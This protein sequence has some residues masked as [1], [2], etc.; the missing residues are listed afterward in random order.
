ML[1]GLPSGI[2]LEASQSL[3]HPF[4][5]P[6]LEELFVFL[7]FGLLGAW[8]I[9]LHILLDKKLHGCLT[10]KGTFGTGREELHEQFTLLVVVPML[11]LFLHHGL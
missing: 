4:S 11:C 7:Y 8:R 5:G 3:T 10:L 9:A 2:I 1:V 6:A